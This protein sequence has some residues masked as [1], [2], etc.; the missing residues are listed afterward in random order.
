M[1]IVTLLHATIGGTAVNSSTGSDAS[2]HTV[3]CD[4]DAILFGV[5]I[6]ISEMT[7]PDIIQMTHNHFY[8]TF[9]LGDT[10]KVVTEIKKN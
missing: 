4:A 7:T 3:G 5:F 6:N 9:P 2:S 1:A 10:G 8:E